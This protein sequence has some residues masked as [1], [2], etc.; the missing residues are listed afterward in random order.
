MLHILGAEKVHFSHNDVHPEVDHTIKHLNRLK[1]VETWKYKNPSEI[2]NGTL[3]QDRLYQVNDLTDCFYR[4][5]NLY[6][7]VAVLDFDEVIMPMLSSDKT[8]EDLVTRANFIPFRDVYIASNVYYPN[9]PPSPHK[10]I[11]EFMYML[12]HIQRSQNYSLYG[13]EK[14][15]LSTKR[16]L[17]VHNHMP[18][19]C[20]SN[21]YHNCSSL[22]FPISV[23][24]NSHYRNKLD[25]NSGYE[26][27]VEDTTIWK[28]KEQLIKVV[29]ETLK[30]IGLDP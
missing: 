7:Y 17:S 22:R 30:A 25:L 3:F 6:D 2:E 1:L 9:K 20:L 8:W 19:Q 27:T 28:Y 21:E 24:Q 26:L 23:A 5:K 13:A 18:H 12:Q 14:S 16:V 10:G 11:P 29:S 4:V 15:F